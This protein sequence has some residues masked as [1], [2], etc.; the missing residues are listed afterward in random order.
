MCEDVKHQTNIG[1]DALGAN[2][3]EAG[4]CLCIEAKRPRQILI[5]W[6]VRRRFPTIHS[7]TSGA[8]AGRFW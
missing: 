1:I 2:V 8:L 4:H 6:C 7:L 3:V 5:E